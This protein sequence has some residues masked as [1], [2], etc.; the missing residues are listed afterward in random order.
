MLAEVVGR[1][2]CL[3]LLL[4]KSLSKAFQLEPS[5]AVRVVFGVFFSVVV[6]EWFTDRTENNQERPFPTQ[7]TCLAPMVWSH[8]QQ[9]LCVDQTCH[10]CR[11]P[12]GNCGSIG[13]G[14]VTSEPSSPRE[15]QHTL[16]YHC[17]C[18]C[19]VKCVYSP[20]C[21]VDKERQKH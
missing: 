12:P 16:R 10:G 11:A 8:L 2:C 21:A 6:I 5:S 7:E 1:A 4:V 15:L 3:S 13:S 9:T 17:D 20:S 14:P 18:L 19:L